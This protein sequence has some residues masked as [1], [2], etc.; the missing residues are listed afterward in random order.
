MAGEVS[1]ACCFSAAVSFDCKF[2][3]CAHLA[4]FSADLSA[5]F[6]R[7]SVFS[8]FL[9]EHVAKTRFAWQSSG[10]ADKGKNIWW[11]QKHFM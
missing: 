7:I 8:T 3:D 10:D 9:R 1:V 2:N 6:C 4:Q 5:A 11:G